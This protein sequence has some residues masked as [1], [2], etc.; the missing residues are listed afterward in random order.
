MFRALKPMANNRKWWYAVPFL[1]VLAAIFILSSQSYGQQ[2]IRPWLSSHAVQEKLLR[3]LNGVSFTWDGREM[4]V[5]SMGA[6]NLAEFIIRKTAH[7]IV[8]AG[9]SCTLLLAFWV[10]FSWHKIIAIFNTVVLSLIFALFDE[11]NQQYS[12][13]RTSRVSDV[14][15]D[16]AGVLLGILLFLAA[17]G[18][19]KVYRMKKE[20]RNKRNAR[21]ARLFHDLNDT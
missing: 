4:S 8:Y 19:Y 5:T 12:G 6:Q 7:V 14:A 15:I 18:I 10:L 20:R 2:D 13:A 16:M 11:F 9:L 17:R 3:Y 21:K 1:A